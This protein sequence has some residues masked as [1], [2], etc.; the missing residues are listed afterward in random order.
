MI[1][2]VIV[3]LIVD[4]T[5]E[6]CGRL[7]L[8]ARLTITITIHD[9]YGGGLLPTIFGKHKFWQAAGPPSVIKVQSDEQ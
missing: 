4:R 6:Y 5:Y 2:I 7:R 3:N 8:R 1:L 9:Y